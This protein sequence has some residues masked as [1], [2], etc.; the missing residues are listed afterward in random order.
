MMEKN[1]ASDSLALKRDDQQ[2]IL[3]R[4]ITINKN[5]SVKVIADVPQRSVLGPILWNILYDE[6]LE[7]K[8]I[9]G[10]TCLPYG[11]NRAALIGAKNSP[12]LVYRVNESLQRIVT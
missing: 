6:V 5:A 1:L 7:L 9:E 11:D 10:A 3:C 12:Q 8:L 2:Y 4:T